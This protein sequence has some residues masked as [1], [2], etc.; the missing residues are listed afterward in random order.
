MAAAQQGQD[1]ILATDLTESLGNLS[2]DTEE[3]TVGAEKLKEQTLAAN[4]ERTVSSNVSHDPKNVGPSSDIPGQPDT[5]DA[6]R[7]GNAVYPPTVYAPQAHPVYYGGYENTTNQWDEYPQ[8]VNSE[9]IEL[10]SPGLY[11]E[12]P[13]LVFHT[14]YGYN[15]QIPYGPYSPVTTPMPSV[16]G[17]GQMYSPQQ[18]PFTGPYYQQ[19]VP[20]NVPFINSQTMVSQ[21]ELSV[22]AGGDQQGFDLFGSGPWTDWSK[23]PDGHRSLGSLP[24]PPVSPQPLTAMGSFTHNSPVAAGVGSQQQRP[25]YGFGSTANSYGRNYQHGA[26]YQ[27]TSFGG[28]NSALAMSGR[29]WV[30]TDKGRRRGRGPGSLCS[31]NGALDVLNEQNR[32]PRASRNKAQAR[33][34]S[35][36]GKVIESNTANG[37]SELYNR[38]DFAIDYKD[39]KFF[40]IKSYSEDNVHKSIKYGVWASTANGNRRLDAAYREAKEKDPSCPIFLFFS[41]NASAHFCGVAEMMGPVDFD[42]SVD[43]WQQDKWSGQFPVKWHIIKD[44]P[45]T[46]F[47]HIILENN[48]NKPVTNSRDTQEVKL[49]QGLEILKI[50]KN[51]E[52]DQSILQDFNYYEEREMIMQKRKARLRLQES[53][54]E[55]QLEEKRSPRGGLVTQPT[56][57][58]TQ[59]G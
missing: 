21:P 42:K 56:D 2:I 3:K 57:I 52:S 20:P 35:A 6:S 13:S 7:D 1:R 46:Q 27:G 8:Y 44:I 59:S 15:P 9:R 18:F 12:N 37:Q 38:P 23:I 26:M 47:R 36:D 24:A 51:H 16:R 55:D 50:F 14:G 39:A 40:I 29:S 28:S 30:S 49:E 53:G 32:G 4:D 19:P 33:N 41:V 17:D 10:A 25:L 31:C 11:N 22:P 54:F 48:D 43:Y 34:S 58:A 5:I 45:N